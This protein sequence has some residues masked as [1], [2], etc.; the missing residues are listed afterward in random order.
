VNDLSLTYKLKVLRYFLFKGFFLEKFRRYLLIFFLCVISSNVMAQQNDE[1]R[2][3]GSQIVDDTTK[4]IYGPKT[5]L[6]TTEK[7]LFY[8]KK[9]Y[10]V[11]DT[12]INNYHR[13]TWIQRFNNLYKDLGNIG[14]ALNPIFPTFSSVIGVTSGFN[15]YNL[16]YEIEE[17]KYFDTKSPYSRMFIIWGGKGRAMTRVEFSRNITPRWNFGFNYR[18]MLIDRQL[19]RQKGQRQTISH[20]YD[21]YT[22]Y[23]SKNDRY[24]LLMNYRRIRHRV[25]ESGGADV[26]PGE[27]F[28]NYFDPQTGQ[29]LV[30]TGSEDLRNNVHLLHEYKLAK[31][32]QIYHSGDL[33]KQ[34]NSFANITS[35]DPKDFYDSVA[36]ASDTIS[37]KTTLKIFQNEVGIKGNAAFLFYNFYYKNRSYQY[38]NQKL[39]IDELSFKPKSVE[40][41]VGGRIAFEIDSLT[42]LG[43][44]AEYLLDG[45]YRIEGEFSSPWLDANVKSLFSKPGLMQTSYS[46]GHDYWNNTFSDISLNQVSGFLKVR[47]GPVVISPGATF[48]TTKNYVFFREITPTSPSTQKVLPFQSTGVQTIF[49]PELRMSI[50]FLKN[51]YLRPQVIYTSFLQNDDNAFRIPQLFANAQLAYEGKIFKGKLQVQIGLDA[52]WKSSYMATGYDPAIQQFYNQDSTIIPSFLLA[53][54]F[55]VGKMKSGRFFIKYNNLVQAFTNSGYLTAPGYPGQANIIDFGFDILLFD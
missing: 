46:G 41:Y 10:A 42:E 37:D 5:T 43:G 23:K 29:K 1:V 19:L 8:N 18:P 38:T 12:S 51:I 17:P 50:R 15:S 34:V 36:V 31:P 3:T 44:N 33:G 16:F 2:R 13:W 24:F 45:N 49:S 40:H 21:L 11:L 25:A 54:A 6:W 32:F 39:E 52:H 14:T 22:T 48:S 55:F 27:P 53:D 26:A 20:Y 35:Q 47:V 4:N 30:A 28:V 7:N 9:A